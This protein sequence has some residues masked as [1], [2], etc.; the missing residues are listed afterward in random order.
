MDDGL[1]PLFD[2]DPAR[3]AQPAYVRQGTVLAWDQI[4]ATNTI[5]V[6]SS[7]FT[8]LPILASSAEVMLMVPGDTVLLQVVGKGAA[9]QMYIIGRVT[10]PGTAQAAT[11]LN[12]I[13]METDEV[14]TQQATTS[15]NWTDL[16]TVGPQVTITVRPSGRVLVLYSGQIGW[17]IAAAGSV[18]GRMGIDVSGANTMALTGTVATDRWLR[19]QIEAGGATTNT[20]IFGVGGSKMFEGLAPGSTTFKIKYRSSFG[21]SIDFDNRTIVAIPL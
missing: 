4:D 5:K 21:Q 15:T 3:A 7:A 2:G 12:M 18:G 11:A 19:A 20:G 16:S 8:N 6:G 10:V 9:A 13:G 1:D 14:L 17:A